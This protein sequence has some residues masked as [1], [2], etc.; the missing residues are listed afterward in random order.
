[1]NIQD[2]NPFL[3]AAELQPAVLEGK[4]DRM[5]Y[6]HRLFYILEGCGELILE[7]R[8]TPLSPDMAILLRPGVGYHFRGK[9]RVAVLNFDLTRSAVA[10]TTPI[11]PPPIAKF[12]SAQ[13][14]DSESL[15]VLEKPLLLSDARAFKT[16]VLTIVRSFSQGDALSDAL[17]SALL[18]KLFAELLASMQRAA[19]P[20]EALVERVRRYIHLYAAEITDNRALGEVF[21]YHPVYL[22]QVFHQHTGKNLHHAILEARIE[23]ACQWLSRTDHSIERIAFDTGFSSRNHF[24][25]VFRRIMGVTPLSYRSKQ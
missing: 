6:D 9:M 15:D 22:A 8:A 1:M 5:A 10:K 14:F 12:D 21:G 7:A 20:T 13:I 23:L 16:D 25:T 24:C 17:C 4:G 2:C 18:K 3:R 19:S 11:C